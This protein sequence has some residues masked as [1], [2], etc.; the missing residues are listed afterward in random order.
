[1]G[2]LS[3]ILTG[4][5]KAVKRC[6]CQFLAKLDLLPGH[7]VDLF[8]QVQFS[9]CKKIKGLAPCRP[10][11][12][13]CKRFASFLKQSSTAASSYVLAALE[14]SFNKKTSIQ[15][16]HNCVKFCI[17]VDLFSARYHPARLSRVIRCY[18]Y[19]KQWVGIDDECFQ[20]LCV[21]F[22]M[23]FRVGEWVQ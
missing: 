14:K 15:M 1:M 7:F 9:S 13:F 21:N 6:C 8:T 23:L 12:C 4:K 10:F 19:C 5:Q 22:L 20:F 16:C 11:V 3:I 17:I 2:S 18:P